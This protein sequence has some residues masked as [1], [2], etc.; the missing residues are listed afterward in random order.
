MKHEIHQNRTIWH[1]KCKWSS[2]FE[3]QPWQ[4]LSNN[5]QFSRYEEQTASEIW[6]SNFVKQGKERNK[7]KYWIGGKKTFKI[8]GQF[9]NIILVTTKHTDF[10]LE[11]WKLFYI[12]T[13]LKMILNYHKPCGNGLMPCGLLEFN[14]EQ[15]VKSKLKLVKSNNFL[16]ERRN[17]I[18]WF[19]ESIGL[20][21][22][23]VWKT[24]KTLIRCST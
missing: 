5:A 1:R 18:E 19:T 16:R 3:R 15:K 8:Q 13:I 23:N 4:D 11:F 10:Q 21:T 22:E 20:T 7:E 2:P 14:Q 6:I 24:Q 9:R 12:T 17:L